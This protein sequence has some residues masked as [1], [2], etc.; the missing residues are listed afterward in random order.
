MCVE[1]HDAYVGH[2]GMLRREAAALKKAAK[3][4]AF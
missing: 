3:M 1:K 2:Q 4:A